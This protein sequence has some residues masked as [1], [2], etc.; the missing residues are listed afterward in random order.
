MENVPP[1]PAPTTEDRGLSR[2]SSIVASDSESNSSD[3]ELGSADS[4][5]SAGSE[6]SDD[7]YSDDSFIVDS[8]LEDTDDGSEPDDASVPEHEGA[9][10]AARVSPSGVSRL[11]SVIAK[12]ESAHIAKMRRRDRDHGHDA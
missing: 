11:Q 12:Y 3:I 1:D 6:Q 4:N 7:E 10:N 8:D 9:A 5:A 2:A